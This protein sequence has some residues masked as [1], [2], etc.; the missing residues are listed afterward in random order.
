MN[1][2]F[3]FRGALEAHHATRE[4]VVPEEVEP[5]SGTVAGDL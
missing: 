5:E 2:K 3:N 1:L 4:D